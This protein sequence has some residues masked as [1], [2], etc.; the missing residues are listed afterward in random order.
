MTATDEEEIK[1]HEN[2]NIDIGIVVQ[3]SLVFP[4]TGAGCENPREVGLHGLL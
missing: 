4:K 3:H 2:D 1:A